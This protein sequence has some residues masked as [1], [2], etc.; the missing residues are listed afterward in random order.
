LT[1]KILT[2]DYKIPEC[3]KPSIFMGERQ[4]SVLVLLKKSLRSR[5][6]NKSLCKLRGLVILFAFTLSRCPRIGSATHVQH[7]EEEEEGRPHGSDIILCY[8]SLK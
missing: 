2:E 1:T 4:S 3:G 5:V 7:Q 6:I 8:Y